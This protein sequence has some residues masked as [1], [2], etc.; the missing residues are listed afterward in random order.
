MD[1]MWNLI[2][3][4]ECMEYVPVYS[5]GHSLLHRSLQHPQISRPRPQQRPGRFK[6]LRLAVTRSSRSGFPPAPAPAPAPPTTLPPTAAPTTFKAQLRHLFTWRSDNSALPVV[7]VPF[8][9]AKEVRSV[10]AYHSLQCLMD[11][12]IAQCCSGCS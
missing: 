2:S 11:K 12:Y 6:K 8:A 5:S 9:Q 10:D 3:F 4:G 7:D 1:M